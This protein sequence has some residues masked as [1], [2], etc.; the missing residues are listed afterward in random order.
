MKT[1][2]TE[3]RQL[4]KAFEI[5]VAIRAIWQGSHRRV[6]RCLGTIRQCCCNP[7]HQ[8]TQ[9]PVPSIQSLCLLG[10]LVS[11][12]QDMFDCSHWQGGHACLS[13]RHYIIMDSPLFP[14]NS[15]INLTCKD[16]RTSI[17]STFKSK[18]PILHKQSLARIKNDNDVDKQQSQPKPL[19]TSKSCSLY[20]GVR[21]LNYYFS[22]LSLTVL[23]L[24]AC[25]KTLRAGMPRLLP[26]TTKLI[27]AA[28][29]RRSQDKNIKPSPSPA[30]RLSLD[31]FLPK[32]Q[33]DH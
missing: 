7:I 26:T 24:H 1:R 33:Y 30:Q 5:S 19:R 27:T 16:G 17:I 28:R 4:R 13:H 23:S 11:T 32:Q 14:S 8:Q 31:T 21:R 3:C 25:R 9:V 20:R 22:L 12:I 6:K 2:D 10:C 15:R 29:P 18:W